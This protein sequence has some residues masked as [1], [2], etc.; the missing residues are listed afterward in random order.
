MNPPEFAK[1][2]NL[3]AVPVDGSVKAVLGDDGYY[4]MNSKDGKIIAVMLTK[5]DVV[6]DRIGDAINTWTNALISDEENNKVYDYKGLINF[7]TFFV[8]AD[9]VYGL[10]EDLYKFLQTFADRFAGAS[11]SNK[12][13]NWLLDRKSTRLNSSHM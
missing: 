5:T 10:N 1:E 13:N 12:E 2:K 8:N 11:V 9:G 3:T 6:G 7:Y 4:H